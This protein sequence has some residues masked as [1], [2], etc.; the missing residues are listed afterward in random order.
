L[1]QFQSADPLFGTAFAI[2][3]EKGGKKTVK[4]NL[5]FQ[6]FILVCALSWIELANADAVSDW[7]VIAFQAEATAGRTPPVLF[8]DLAMMHT[9]IHDAV[10]AYEGRFEHYCTAISNAD[11][12]PVA[13]TA[14]AAHDV[15]V[16][17]FPE[18]ALALDAAY[19]TYL[20]N[21]ELSEDDPGVEIGQLAA[22][23]IVALR[24][25]DGSFPPNQDPFMGGTDPGVWRPTPPAF[26]PG[27][28]PWLGAVTP[29]ALDGTDQ[30]NAVAPPKLSSGRYTQEY[31]EV[32]ALGSK[33][34]TE[35]TPEQ[36]DMANFW[37]DNSAQ[38]W[39]RLLRAL[40]ANLDSLGDSARMF[41]LTYLANADAGI[42]AWNSKYSYVYWRPV[43]AIQEGDNDGNPNTIGDPAW[44]PVLNTPPY[45]EYTSGANNVSGSTTRTLHRFFGTNHMEFSLTSNFPPTIDKER[46][47]SKFSDAAD[48]VVEVRIL[49]GIHFRSADKNAKKQGKKVAD[50]VFEKYLRPIGD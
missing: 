39:A 13:A 25:N 22:A 8:L 4:K 46:D 50:Y 29:F 20:A 30:C 36:T 10:Q 18:Q 9:A 32:K 26:A 12:S 15:L 3:V 5:L 40:A 33:T 27:S 6:F 24:E 42:C 23:C 35:R 16:S 21:N 34:S 19:R 49:Q 43:T 28:F 41:A 38:I 45:P 37:S 17:R 47:Y 2:A 1:K 14:K 11:G 48:E 31:N 44:L 7:N